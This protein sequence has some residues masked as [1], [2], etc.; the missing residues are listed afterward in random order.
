MIIKPEKITIEITNRCNLSCEM[1]YLAGANRKKL[2]NKLDS[3]LSFE[4]F[5]KIIDE[6][7]E[8]FTSVKKEKPFSLILTGGEV[9]L[10]PDILKM[11][12]YIEEKKIGVTIFTNGTLINLNL[13]SEIVKRNP[14]AL[15]FSIDGPEEI[16]DQIR[17][18]G[19]FKKT[20]A[21]I[22]LLQE[23]KERLNLKHPKI[24]V[25]TL[26]N[27]LN[28]NYLE[29][30]IHICKK[31]RIDGLSFSHIQWSNT[32]STKIALKEL[33]QRLSWQ[34]RYLNRTVDFM[35]HNL[36]VKTN[37]I[38]QLLLQ[39][40]L[41]KEKYSNQQT[42][43]IDFIPDLSPKEIK[44]WYSTKSNNYIDFCST[45]KEWIRIGANGDVYPVCALIPFHLGNLRKQTLKEIITG[46]RTQKFF[47]EIDTNGCFYSCQR[48]C[49]R[50][51]QS[52]SVLIPKS[53][54]TFL[55]KL[56]FS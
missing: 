24:F 10:H 55:H 19:S 50:P 39:I 31:L 11:L 7:S 3:F 49:R 43:M 48:C 2:T 35:E 38:N 30:F 51:S 20:C 28:I 42:F 18:I 32:N 53:V 1:C 23:Q 27:D 5:K 33:E 16:H 54:N 15:M 56:N 13:A 29:D 41:I 45:P 4:L 21:A 34:P 8:S 47:N 14:V 6:I 26:I 52:K 17:G 36:Y 25:N 44:L 40:N 12:D 37:H 22:N 9:F 46:D